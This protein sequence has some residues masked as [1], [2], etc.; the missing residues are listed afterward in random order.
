MTPASRFER[1]P[2]MS[3]PEDLSPGFFHFISDSAILIS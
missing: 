2:R 1:E 3:K